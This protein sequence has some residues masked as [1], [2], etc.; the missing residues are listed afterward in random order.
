MISNTLSIAASGLA[1]ARTLHTRAAANV[2]H[3]F[4]PTEPNAVAAQADTS[5][6]YQTSESASPAP[7]PGAPI[8]LISAGSDLVGGM[9]DQ[10]IALTAYRANAATFRTADEATESLLDAFA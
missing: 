10:M 3:A 2:V 8:G 7:L 6:S 4:Q 1:A 5:V 9:V